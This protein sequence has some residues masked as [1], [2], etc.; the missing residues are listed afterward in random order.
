M[1]DDQAEQSTT[2]IRRR[3]DIA[4]A[5]IC[6]IV[7]AEMVD[8]ARRWGS[9]LTVGLGF[10]AIGVPL[11]LLEYGAWKRWLAPERIPVRWAIGDVRG[12]RL[13]GIHRTLQAIWVG[14]FVVSWVFTRS[15]HYQLNVAMSAVFWG[16]TAW[17]LWLSRYIADRKY[18]PQPRLPYDRSTGWRAGIKRMRS[19]YWGKQA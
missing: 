5:I 11:L 6:L 18:I 14:S 19:E 16:A 1:T 13:A 17:Y 10:L 9:G 2:P 15:E 3:R 8:V 7:C 12:E 4:E